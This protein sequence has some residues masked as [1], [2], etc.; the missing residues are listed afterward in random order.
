MILTKLPSGQTGLAGAWRRME[1]EIPMG[2]ILIVFSIF[3]LGFSLFHLTAYAIRWVLEGR[4]KKDARGIAE[5]PVSAI[6]LIFAEIACSFAEILLSIVDF[7][8]HLRGYSWRRKIPVRPGSSRPAPGA[9]PQYAGAP[10]HFE[11]P[12]PIVLLHGAGMRGLAMYP[13]AR[14][15]RAEGR[16]VHMFTHWPPGQPIGAY[17]RQL[18]GYLESLCQKH[19]YRDFD[20]VGHSLGGLVLRR[21][22]AVHPEG[23]PIKRMVTLGTPHGGSELWRFLPTNTGKQLRPGGQILKALDEAGVPDGVEVTAVS[24]DFDQ[25]VVP[26]ALARWEA[27]GVSNLTVPNSGHSRLVFHPETFRIVLEA[28][29]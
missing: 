24:S 29:S 11:G 27:S 3:I 19:G 5:A 16:S 6:V 7:L 20:A 1:A 28:L 17:A 25:L 14:K 26:N 12:R 21:Y 22:L 23:P 4:E 15:L 18:R 2:F 10:P 8:L 13:L 9:P